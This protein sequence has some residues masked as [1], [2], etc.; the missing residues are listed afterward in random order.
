LRL[1]NSKELSTLGFCAIRWPYRTLR[2]WR[3]GNSGEKEP[4]MQTMFKAI[5]AAALVMLVAGPAMAKSNAY[6]HAQARQIA[7]AQ[8]AGK[9]VVGA[10]V[11]CILGAIITGRCGPGLA[12]GGV[13]GFA[14]GG[15]EWNR[16]YKNAYWRCKNS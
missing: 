3:R 2:G 4:M 13:T 6:C 12:V 15:V 14:V 5:A 10:G 7:N 9:T 11:G 1:K 8:A 16:V